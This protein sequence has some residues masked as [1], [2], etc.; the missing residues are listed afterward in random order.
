MDGLTFKQQALLSVAFMLVLVTVGFAFKAGLPGAFM[1]DDFDN[2]GAMSG[3]VDVNDASSVK[4]YLDKG[5]AG[6]LGRPI[7]KLSFLLDDNAWPSEPAGYKKTN[8]LIHL[9]IGVVIFSLG[10]RLF[11]LLTPAITANWLSLG[12]AALWLAH[13]MQVSTVLYPVQRM[14]QL[15]ALFVLLGVFLH[16]VVRMRSGERPGLT[17]LLLMSVSWVI[18]TALAAFSKENG[19]LLPV[20]LLVVELTVLSRFQSGKL[21][22]WWKIL[23]LY[24]P[25]IVIVAYVFNLPRWADSYTIRTFSMYDRLLTQPVVLLDYLGSIFSWQVSGLGLFQDD[26]NIYRS[27]RPPVVFSFLIIVGLLVHA[28][29]V[30]R[31]YPAISLGILWY[32]AGHLLESTTIPLEIYFEH[33]N[34]LPLVGPVIVIVWGVYALLRRFSQDVDMTRF[35]GIFIPIL[36]A[37]STSIT[38]GYAGEWSELRR[39]IPIWAVEHPDSP[40]AQRT[41]AHFLAASAMPREALFS[42]EE[43]Y[44]RFPFDISIPVMMTDIACRYGEKSPVALSDVLDNVDHHRWTDGLRPALDSIVQGIMEGRCG[45][46]PGEVHEFIWAMFDLHEGERHRASMASILVLDGNLHMWERDANSALRSYQTVDQMLPSVDSILRIAGVFVAVGDYPKV[47]EALNI[48]MERE[49]QAGRLT[50][51]LRD[52]YLLKIERYKALAHAAR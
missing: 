43:S 29:S 32:F 9:L 38:W 21:L 31:K 37:I 17:A 8:I 33:R 19:V 51:K 46:N 6:P 18:C 40:R 49:R 12:V 15:A 24:L 42:L 30:R 26:F 25:T 4:S 1:L 48:A 50:N 27:I 11:L 13:P 28:I 20:L 16:V 35:S 41:Y 36:F 23:F 10:R 45:L 5:K 52:E 14:S 39:I 22:L 3:G 44:A 2:L 47:I 34:Y 7:A